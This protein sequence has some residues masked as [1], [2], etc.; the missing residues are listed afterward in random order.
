MSYANIIEGLLQQGTSPQSHQRLRNG[1]EYA[2][3]TGGIEDILGSL[4]GGAAG[5]PGATG[6][7]RRAGS[8]GPARPGALPRWRATSSA[9]RRPAA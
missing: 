2:D 4:L 8:T 9:S 6:A 5:T 3:R 7:R 1:A